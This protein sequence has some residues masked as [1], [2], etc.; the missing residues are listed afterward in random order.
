[1]DPNAT[2]AE[3]RLALVRAKEHGLD[4]VEVARLTVQLVTAETFMVRRRV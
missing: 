1:M 4:L 2:K 3:R